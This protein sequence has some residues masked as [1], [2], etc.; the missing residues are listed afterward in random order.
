MPARR[1]ID[2]LFH[3]LLA[4]APRMRRTYYFNTGLMMARPDDEDVRAAVKDVLA[5]SLLYPDMSRRI[6]FPEQTLMNLAL[7][8]RGVRCRDLFG[9]CVASYHDEE[10]GW[11]APVARHYLGDAIRR[12]PE[13]LRSRHRDVVDGALSAIGTSVDELRRRGL[14]P[15]PV[16]AEAWNAAGRRPTRGIG[17]SPAAVS[18]DGDGWLSAVP[19]RVRRHFNDCTLLLATV[20]PTELR[21]VRLS[22]PEIPPGKAR[23]G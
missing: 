6:S 23:S 19:H 2:Q 22:F 4:S 1:Q 12:Q 18:R 9:L 11:P 7:M 10:R 17:A 13:V 5:A 16:T 15:E 3:G 14:W 8:V 20:I 21:S